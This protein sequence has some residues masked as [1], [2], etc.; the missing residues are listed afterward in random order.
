MAFSREN[1]RRVN[2]ILAQR[3]TD[4]ENT[5]KRNTERLYEKNPE[6]KAVD[7]ALS[8]TG[9]ELVRI[10]LSKGD[11]KAELAR[12]R[13]ENEA[14]QK[15]RRALLF[16]MG[17]SADYTEVKHT[18]AACRDTGYTE[19]GMCKCMR[20]L[21]TEEGFRSSGLGGLIE[22]QCFDN[23]SL[24]FYKG[25]DLEAVS[26]ALSAAKQFAE[27]FDKTHANLLFIGGTGLGKTHLSTAIAR[28]AIERGQ[29]VVYETAQNI[30]A[31]FEYDRFRRGYE[32]SARSEK[33]LEADLLIM[34]D[35]GV[36][37]TTQF[38]VSALYTIIN[39]RI[40]QGK[41]MII[42][43]NLGQRALLDRYDE[44]ITSRLF[45]EFYPFLFKG[46]DIRGQK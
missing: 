26:R 12:V 46:K 23:F 8:R 18:C 1:M 7:A 2:D 30:I 3:R 31:D 9:L 29:D 22:K 14:L 25:D 43:T 21:L 40:N 33:Y 34:D 5:A 44:R 37:L 27:D 38:T 17:L 28:R 19:A 20:R 6:V 11:V 4:A 45:G 42:S 41:S 16:D 35:L 32:E 10:A 39:T 13:E 15:K 36:E 24:H